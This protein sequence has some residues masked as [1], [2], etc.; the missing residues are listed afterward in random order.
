MKAKYGPV[1]GGQGV[2]Q[3]LVGKKGNSKEKGQG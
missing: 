2:I 1:G 3:K